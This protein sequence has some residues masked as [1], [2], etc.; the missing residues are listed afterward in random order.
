MSLL[1]AVKNWLYRR[2]TRI[3]ANWNYSKLANKGFAGITW[4][5]ILGA[6]HW[7]HVS[8]PDLYVCTV[9]GALDSNRK[10]RRL[11]QAYAKIDRPE[12]LRHAKSPIAERLQEIK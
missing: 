12:N 1:N 5:P 11:E 9:E 2:Y 7:R 10:W 3:I 4:T 8:Q 6:V